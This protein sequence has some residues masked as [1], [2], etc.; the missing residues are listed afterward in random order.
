MDEARQ[1]IKETPPAQ[2]PKRRAATTSYVP[3]QA[4]FSTLDRSRFLIQRFRSDQVP[5]V[6]TT[7]TTEPALAGP[8]DTFVYTEGRQSVVNRCGKQS[9]SVGPVSSTCPEAQDNQQNESAAGSPGRRPGTVTSPVQQ[10]I[11][12]QGQTSP[13]GQVFITSPVPLQPRMRILRAP[14]PRPNTPRVRLDLPPGDRYQRRLPEAPD[15][16]LLGGRPQNPYYQRQL[17]DPYRA[18]DTADQTFTGYYDQ[19]TYHLPSGGRYPGYQYPVNT[20]MGQ[21]LSQYYYSTNLDPY[22]MTPMPN[23]QSQ[24]IQGYY[25]RNLVPLVS[26]QYQPMIPQPFPQMG[27]GNMAG[28]T[29]DEGIR[30]LTGAVRHLCD[31]VRSSHS[32][33][34]STPIP[35]SRT[36]EEEQVHVTQPSVPVCQPR[37]APTGSTNTTTVAA[38]S[39]NTATNVTAS[40]GFTHSTEPP[41]V[42]SGPQLDRSLRDRIVSAFLDDLSHVS[43]EESFQAIEKAVKAKIITDAEAG[44]YFSR[45]VRD[46]PLQTPVTSQ[47]PVGRGHTTQEGPRVTQAPPEPWMSG[48]LDII[49]RRPGPPGYDSSTVSRPSGPT[50]L[51]QQERTLPLGGRYQ[52]PPMVPQ[53]PPQG[54]PIVQQVAEMPVCMPY[55]DIR[56]HG[57]SYTPTQRDSVSA[58]VFQQSGIQEAWPSQQQHTGYRNNYESCADK[59]RRRD[60][61][62]A[63]KDLTFDGTEKSLDWEFFADRFQ[64]AVSLAAELWTPEQRRLKLLACLKGAAARCV[65]S[66]AGSS[67]EELWRILQQRF[68]SVGQE[69]AYELKLMKRQRDIVKETPQGFLDD[70]SFLC[71]RAYPRSSS[72]DLEMTIKKYF[73]LGHPTAYQNHLNASVNREKGT[74]SDLIQACRQYEQLD[75]FRSTVTARRPGVKA[76]D[77]EQSD[78]FGRT[79]AAVA[80]GSDPYRSDSFYDEGDEEADICLTQSRNRRRRPK[81]SRADVKAV[82]EEIEYVPPYNIFSLDPYLNYGY[83]EDPG[84]NSLSEE[85]E[86]AFDEKLDWAIASVNMIRPK[87]SSTF[88]RPHTPTG[89]PRFR[90][91]MLCAYCNRMGHIF[92]YCRKLQGDF[93]D[94]KFPPHVCQMIINQLMSGAYNEQFQRKRVPD[95]GK[96]GCAPPGVRAIEAPPPV[97]STETQVSGKG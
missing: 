1:R 14:S 18:R 79:V 50:K 93:P 70:I 84:L 26:N 77:Y 85:A 6:C 89:Q 81:Q 21:E 95:D 91:P 31:V 2:L 37:V 5:L 46:V 62:F 63:L 54:P 40:T 88:Y 32:L 28:N 39:S 73:V 41:S 13:T 7:T 38:T 45:K 24:L 75:L 11:N 33:A 48:P 60:A 53:V 35:Q 52:E 72:Y 20:P 90:K 66:F 55:Q 22:G 10:V 69:S 76:L 67:V 34:T 51:Q 9:P 49:G 64:S 23:Q 65:T 16:S 80:E 94:G 15:R 83:D 78:N 36:Q 25:P 58:P 97:D 57:F 71:K 82:K 92:R 59:N 61:D 56:Q 74:L 47:P 42:T 30:E 87:L 43:L 8:G 68:S 29:Q 3:E 27:V 4:I 17:P 86:T 44:T 96:Q 12:T 19:D